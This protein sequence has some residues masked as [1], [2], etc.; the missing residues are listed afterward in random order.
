MGPEHIESGSGE[1]EVAEAAVELFLEV[2]MIERLS[3][4]GP[5]EMCID[6]EH[7]A[8]DGLADLD[9]ILG[10]A[11]SFSHP[12]RLPRA[13]QLGKRCCGNARIVSIRDSRGLGREYLCVVNLA[14]DPSLHKRNV[15]L[16]R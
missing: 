15:L 7:L 6:T 1:N 2:Q 4:V 16:G 11:G 5:V 3:E 8:E 9:E 14:R 10:E 12:V 13:S